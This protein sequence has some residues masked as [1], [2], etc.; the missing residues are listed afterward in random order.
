MARFLDTNVL[1]RYFT[2]DDPIRAQHA[3]ALIERIERDEEHVVT[4]LMIVFETVFLL[5]RRY[6]V[7]KARARDLIWDV[8]SM[9]GV[10]L[11]EKSLCA[12]ALDLYVERNISLADAYSAVFMRS[13]GITEVY[14]WD[15]DFD[16]IPGLSRIEPGG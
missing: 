7:P 16:K 3:L 1:M 2:N 14:S 4:S 15:A 11:A 6:K 9:R 12:Q 5:E 10:Q 8:L 13:R